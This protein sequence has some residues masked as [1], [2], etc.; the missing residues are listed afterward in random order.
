RLDYLASLGVT[1]LWLLPFFPT[2]NHDNGYDIIDYYGVDERHGSL[3][4]CVAFLHDARARGLEVIIDLVLHHTSD[5]HPWFQQ[6]REGGPYRDFYV[7]TDDPPDETAAEVIFPGVEQGIWARDEQAGA[8]YLHH[9]YSFEPDLNIEHPAVRREIQ[10]IVGMWL[11]LGVSGFRVDA[12]SRMLGREALL[13]QAEQQPHEFLRYLRSIV[14]ARDGR[15]ALIAETDVEV[16]RLATYFGDGD[17]MQLL[18]NFWLDNHLFLALAR[19]EAEPIVRAFRAMPEKPSVGQWANFVRNLDELDLERLSVEEQEEVYAVFAPDEEMRIYRRG[20]R[21]RL[22]PMLGG[23]RRRLEL[24]YSLLFSLPGTP[25]LVYG[26]EIGMGDDLALPERWSVR[27]P[28]QWSCDA[29]AGFSDAPEDAVVRPVVSEGEFGYQHV[30]VVDQRRDPDSLLNWMQRVIRMRR[31]N[32]EIG[33]GELTLIETDQPNVLAHRC[34]SEGGTLMTVHN[35]SGASCTATLS[36]G[37]L[38]LA[39]AVEIFGDHDYG[40]VQEELPSIRLDAYGYRWFR[41]GGV[42]L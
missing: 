19:E 10:K 25:V 13:P 3:G 8:W 26:D 24:V 16:E 37:D 6:S 39:A 32:P 41:C 21:R 30:N 7:W 38:D 22:A 1:C 31:Q 36:P 9:F 42:Q 15:A 14:S 4:D 11:Q 5:Q 35:L 28:M 40:P 17:Q 20:I 2:P 12:A 27:T 34:D 18:L 29:N 33:W 23:D